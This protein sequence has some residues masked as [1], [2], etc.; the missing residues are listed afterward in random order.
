MGEAK[1][2][3]LDGFFRKEREF[4]ARPGSACSPSSGAQSL[5]P[6]TAPGLSGPQGAALALAHAFPAL[7]QGLLRALRGP[8]GE[9]GLGWGRPPSLP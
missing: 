8:G 4:P 7:V 3:H 9:P 5:P 1:Q 2:K 6:L